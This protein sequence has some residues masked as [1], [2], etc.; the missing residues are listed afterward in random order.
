[1]TKSQMLLSRLIE[2]RLTPNADQV[3][4]D[5]RITALFEE[6]WCVVFSDMV[7]FSK[8][9]EVHGMISALC[10]LHEL[11]RVSR[12]IFEASGGFVVK[13]LGDSFL[14]LFRR[15]QDGLSCQLQLNRALLAY[16]ATRD[17]VRHLE[18]GSGIGFGRVLKIGDEDVF[19]REVNAASRLGEDLAKAQEILITDA[20]RAAVMHLP[21][22]DFE[23][24]PGLTFPAFRVVARDR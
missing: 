12:P 11:K 17:P 1:M 8:H 2:E 21:G 20:A 19:G 3:D 23:P 22:V 10:S 5:H 6:E 14:T 16:N 18:I 24:Y 7:G 4:I 9:A 15:P 13:T